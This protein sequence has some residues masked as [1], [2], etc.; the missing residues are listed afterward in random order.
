MP[1]HG[2][3]SRSITGTMNN[4]KR[5]GWFLG[6]IV[7]M[8]APLCLSLVARPALA[9]T[10]SDINELTGLIKEA[11]TKIVQVNCKR[12]IDVVGAKGM[13]LFSKED[14]LDHLVYCKENLDLDDPDEVW[15]VLSHEGT[16]I[17]QACY[18]GPIVKDEYIPRTMRNLKSFAPHY[19]KLVSED[20]SSED[21]R[22]E[23]EAYDMELEER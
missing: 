3:A 22:L 8:I 4:K 5:P 15:E 9:A 18:G 19:Y 2:H 20:Y 12:E 11:G 1:Q 21:Q 13:Y 6:R 23:L 14:K 16:H 7:L 17:M 10:W